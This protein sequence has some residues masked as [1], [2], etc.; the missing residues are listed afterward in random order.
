MKTNLNIATVMLLAV[1]T[2]FTACKDDSDDNSGFEEPNGDKVSELSI[3]EHKT[4]LED[5]G[6]AFVAKMSKASELKTYDVINSFYELTEEDD[7]AYSATLMRVKNMASNPTK[8]TSLKGT[9]VEDGDVGILDS[10]NEEAGVYEWSEAEG[11]FVKTSDATDKIS[12]SFPV[13]SEEATLLI[14]NV[15]SKI[16]TNS[17]AGMSMEVPTSLSAKLT[18]GSTSLFSFNFTG[19]YYDN[20]TPNYLKESLNIEGFYF[21]SVID[22]KNKSL[23]YMDNKFEYNSENI[24][25]CGFAIDGNIDMDEIMDEAVNLDED[26]NP[27]DSQDIINRANAYFQIGNIKIDGLVNAKELIK[28]MSDDS[29]DSE[30]T[31]EDADKETAILNENIQTYIRYAD[32]SEIFA[33]GEFF[34]DEDTYTWYNY[35]N[36]EQ[37][38]TEYY[39]GLRIV[40]PDGSAISSDIFE[41][42]FSDLINDMND[43][44]VDMN[45]NYDLDLDEM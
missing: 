38:E 4:N 34:T 37:T 33:K 22:L 6:I 40:Y 3:E 32:N 11:D 26:G 15:N 42:G 1:T 16:I 21:E 18:L 39:T 12:Y 28:S 30:W 35:Y 5:E 23:V 19:E 17:N 43:M 13:G 9:F 8:N 44:I 2:L 45:N 31:K 14:N 36:E 27:S 20:A 24:F 25:A 29:Y 10:F 7:F 41:S